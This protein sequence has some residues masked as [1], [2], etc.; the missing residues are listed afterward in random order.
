MMAYRQE[1]HSVHHGVMCQPM[2]LLLVQVQ[3]CQCCTRALEL[4]ATAALVISSSVQCRKPHSAA[5]A[6]QSNP[7]SLAWTCS[8][9]ET[10]FSAAQPCVVS[11]YC[12][13]IDHGGR[14]IINLLMHACNIAR[15]CVRHAC[16][17]ARVFILL[18]GSC[19]R[20]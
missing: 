2:A 8:I 5:K 19:D 17:V 6:W 13:A 14:H 12:H 7:F 1:A 18:Y 9:L 15:V 20:K 10:A 4:W 11:Q 16:I 3:V